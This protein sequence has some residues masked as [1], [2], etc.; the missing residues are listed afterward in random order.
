MWQLKRYNKIKLINK[1]LTSSG[2]ATGGI[3]ECFYLVI[4]KNKIDNTKRKV[5]SSHSVVECD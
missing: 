4:S 5:L 1:D 2:I 3:V